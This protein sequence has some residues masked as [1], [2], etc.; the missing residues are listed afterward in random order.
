M[1]NL[2][3]KVDEC[4][5]VKFVFAYSWNHE[6]CPLNGVAGCLLFR[7]CLNGRRDQ[8]WL[9]IISSVSAVEGVKR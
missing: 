7:G 8:N 6:S 5:V 4:P 2:A 1:Y 9:A 3:E